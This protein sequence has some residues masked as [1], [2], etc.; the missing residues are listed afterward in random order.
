MLTFQGEDPLSQRVHNV[1]E[2]RFVRHVEEVLLIWVTGNELDL[3]QERLRVDLK[4]VVVAQDLQE[5]CRE[6]QK[7]GVQVGPIKIQE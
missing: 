1:F 5:E 6:S 4:A 3:L 2:R 7:E